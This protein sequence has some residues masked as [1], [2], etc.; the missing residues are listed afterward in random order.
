MFGHKTIHINLPF[1]KS[2]KL[3]NLKIVGA[4]IKLINSVQARMNISRML[5]VYVE[6]ASIAMCQNDQAFA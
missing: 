5:T 2:R 4:E 1:I 3:K 6:D